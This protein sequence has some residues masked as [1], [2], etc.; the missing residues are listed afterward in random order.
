M[1]MRDQPVAGPAAHEAGAAERAHHVDE[2]GRRDR[3]VVKPVRDLAV[4]VL[5]HRLEQVEERV[6]RI[7]LAGDIMTAREKRIH[8]VGARFPRHVAAGQVLH[9]LLAKLV[10]AEGGP[11]KAENVHVLRQVLLAVERE[12]RGDD[13]LLR[14]IAGR[15]EDDEAEGLVGIQSVSVRGHAVLPVRRWRR[16]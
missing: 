10:V 6:R 7:V 11:G 16:L 12:Q 8:P 5:F 15:A 13:F 1:T 2:N 4:L 14:E 3:Q 9:D